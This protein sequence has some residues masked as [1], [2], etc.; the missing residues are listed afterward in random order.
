MQIGDKYQNKHTGSI[1][2]IGE[3]NGD[4]IIIKLY[5]EDKEWNLK[6]F[7]Q[8]WEEPTDNFE[9]TIPGWGRDASGIKKQR[10]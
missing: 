3:I 2:T 10:R 7:E 4:W 5:G 1:A 9:S 8:N 6:L